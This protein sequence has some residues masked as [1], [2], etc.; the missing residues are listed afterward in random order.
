MVQNIKCSLLV[1]FSRVVRAIRLWR[2]KSPVGR[3]FE[4]WLCHPTTG[5]LFA[6]PAVNGYLFRIREA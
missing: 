1:S 2:I 4:P 6:R 5:K 3:E